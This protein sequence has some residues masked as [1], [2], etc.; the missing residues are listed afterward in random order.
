MTIIQTLPVLAYGDAVG[1]DTVTL[2]KG[3]IEMGYK[4]EIYA[5]HVDHR[6]GDDMAKTFNK[7]PAVKPDDIVIHHMAIGDPCNMKIAKLKCKKVLIYHNITPPELIEAYNAPAAQG[8][9]IGLDELKKMADKFDYAIADS[10]FNK[11]DLIR[12]G[13]KCKID[14]LPILIAF[15]DYETTPAQKVIDNYND[16]VTN[17]LFTG[18]IASNKCQEDVIRSFA[19][20]QKYYN[21]NSR[22]F[23][24]GNENG[25]ENYKRRL[26]TFTK[27]LGVK[28][29]IFTGH[30]KFNEI[31]A[32]YRLADVFLCQSEHEGFCVPLVEAMFFKVPV[33]AFDSTAVPETLGAGGIVLK[34]KNCL[35]TAG[36]IDRLV[37]D[38]ELRKTIIE[39]QQE[40]LADF[41]H[42]KIYERFKMLLETNVLGK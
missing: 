23:L 14:V 25:F 3:L 26:Q 13:F 2:K 32:Y 4:T 1:N 10:E 15:K 29:V 33:I 22:L 41:E 31:L 19:L 36:V 34:E 39:N 12:A 7:M 20:Y 17:I 8:C 27:A 5:G 21:P 24:V 11:Q 16:G 9:R 30:I 6:Y 18:R 40:R 37:K 38:E 28:N 42:K 35:E